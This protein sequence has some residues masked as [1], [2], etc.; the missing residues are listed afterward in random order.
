MKILTKIAGITFR[1]KENPE[2]VNLRPEG[3]VLIMPNNNE[4]AKD[5]VALEVFW[6]WNLLGFISEKHEMY[7]ESTK[8]VI[9]KSIKDCKNP[10]ASIEKCWYKKDGEFNNED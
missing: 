1:I 6:N 10:R 8:D 9:L 5:G 2:F 4:Y 3:E 7:Q